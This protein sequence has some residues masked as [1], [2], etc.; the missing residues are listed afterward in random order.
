MIMG[1]R[2]D[3]TR[4]QLALSAYLGVV[5][6]LVKAFE[7]LG[8]LMPYP[9]DRRLIAVGGG[10]KSLAYR[11]LLADQTRRPVTRV[12]APE[13]TARGAAIQAGAVLLG[14]DIAELRDAWRPATV[15]ECEPRPE[16]IDTPNYETLYEYA[17]ERYSV[18][19]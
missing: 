3:T 13:A 6:G 9:V 7:L 1:M 4:E 10:A 2:S 19:I 17:T 18:Q 11:Q 8:E 12:D 16:R 5:G 14:A 15:D